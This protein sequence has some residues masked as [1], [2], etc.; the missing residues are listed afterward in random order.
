MLKKVCWVVTH[1]IYTSIYYYYYNDNQI[2][3]KVVQQE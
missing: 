1:R 2:I 3:I